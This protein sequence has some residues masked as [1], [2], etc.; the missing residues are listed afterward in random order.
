M[1]LAAQTNTGYLYAIIA[2][3]LFGASTPAAKYLLETIH[4]LFLAGIFYL[5]SGILIF[6]VLIS[7]KL[8]TNIAADATL[9]RRDIK[10]LVAATL[11]GGILAPVFLMVGLTKT[12]ASSAALFLNLEAVFT[13]LAAWYLFKEH[14]SRH[15]VIGMVL[16]VI[17]GFILAWSKHFTIEG[18]S[19]IAFIALACFFWAIDNNVTRNI[20]A[21]DPLKIVA[22]KSLVAGTTNTFLALIFGVVITNHLVLVGVS[23][24]VGFFSYGLSL[25]CFVMALRFIGTGRTSAYFSLAP[26]IGAG[27]AV[28]F[29]KEPVTLQLVLAG[30][31][32]G[33][34]TW[35]HLTEEHGHEHT[36][37]RLIHEH[38]HIHDE[39]HQHS[40][41]SDD[42][43]GEPHSHIH[44]HAP[45]THSHPHFPDIH[46]RHKH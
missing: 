32:M 3:V 21:A 44:E 12:S 36:H 5:G 11:C 46:H 18:L 20:S 30:C 29:L 33:W 15:I 22:I 31:L 17:G 41:H 24:I 6:L 19:G 28:I 42:P 1:K 37:D 38:K 4:P 14:T 8:F 10:W 43:D 2:A 27:L 16:I 9:R 26:F 45:L 39:H 7:K 35:L 34:G 40:H 23:A 25:I 13:A